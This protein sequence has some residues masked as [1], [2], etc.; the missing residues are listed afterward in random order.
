MADEN[1]QLMVSIDGS[2]WSSP[3]TVAEVRQMWLTGSISAKTLVTVDQGE[4]VYLHEIRS[5]I[6]GESPARGGSHQP[7]FYEPPPVAMAPP[8]YQDSME[9]LKV[10]RG[11]SHY[12]ALRGLIESLT[13]LFCVPSLGFA[14]LFFAALLS[15]DTGSA[16][17]L[18]V[19]MSAVAIVI[20]IVLAIAGRQALLLLI[21]IADVLIHANRRS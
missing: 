4:Q 17:V 16:G 18:V 10:I 2:N 20:N 5:T 7:K 14:I 13:L 12:A 19:V 21:D 15:R 3:H 6:L 1:Y 11:R 8:V 9:F